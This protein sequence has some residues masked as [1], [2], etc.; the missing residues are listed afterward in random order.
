MLQARAEHYLARQANRVERKIYLFSR[1]TLLS[2]V[3]LWLS[4]ALVGWHLSA[5]HI[6]LF[7]AVLIAVA[8]IVF[9]WTSSP[10]LGGVFGYLPQVLLISL[11]VSLLITLTAIFPMLVTLMI[12]PV[13]T[14]T[15]AWQAIQILNLKGI[16]IWGI[17][18]TVAAFG[19][20][21]GEL[22]DLV[23]LPSQ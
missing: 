15:L 14:T 13:L 3:L 12:I 5:H 18:I 23:I 4:Y 20:A 8:I 17:L 7:I 2:L 16:Y 9:A 6:F 10:W 22:I 1:M 21:V 11:T 19:L